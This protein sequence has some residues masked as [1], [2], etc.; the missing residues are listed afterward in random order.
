MALM[1]QSLWLMEISLL[2]GRNDKVEIYKGC[3]CGTRLWRGVTPYQ[4]SRRE[5]GEAN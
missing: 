3:V 5:D 2:I 1:F 4:I